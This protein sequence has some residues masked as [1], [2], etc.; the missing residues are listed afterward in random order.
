M[1][2]WVGN[3]V[4]IPNIKPD[5]AAFAFG[6]TIWVQDNY[7]TAPHV[8]VHEV[9]HVLDVLKLGDGNTEYFRDWDDT[10]HSKVFDSDQHLVTDY[11]GKTWRE[12][13]AE[14]GTVNAF[15]VWVPGGLHQLAT[16]F[17]HVKNQVEFV[18]GLLHDEFTALRCNAKVPSGD[19]VWVG[20]HGNQRMA[21]GQIPA[22]PNITISH[23]PEIE[24]DESKLKGE[25]IICDLG[26]G[27][28]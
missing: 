16:P 13:F 28:S 25:I 17:S 10:L 18:G 27:L 21:K 6:R 15:H 1:R 8:M 14:I 12:C 24:V 23:V 2:Q 3:F 5:A 26:F 20:F 11:A 22:K 19:L 9:M 7:W 4:A